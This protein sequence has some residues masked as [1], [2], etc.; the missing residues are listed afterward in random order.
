MEGVME[1]ME[2]TKQSEN[3]FKTWTD[4]QTKMWNDWI[5]LMQGVGKSQSSQIWEKTVEAWDESIKKTLDAQVEWTQ[6]WAESC[7]GAPKEMADWAKQGQDM[8]QGWTET[9][10]QLWG[11][12]FHIVKKL[13]PAASGMNWGGGD[14]QKFLQGWQDAVQKGLDTQAEWV[15]LWSAKQ[16]GTKP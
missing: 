12:W 13:D 2:W 5:K 15:R 1:T 9:Q 7:K 3:L 10:K 4:T 8:I 6:R 11:N 14:G 16:A